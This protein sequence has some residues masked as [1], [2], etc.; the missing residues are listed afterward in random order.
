MGLL[1]KSK[2]VPVP[3][4][5]VKKPRWDPTWDEA[6]AEAAYQESLRVQ[7][8]QS[9]W[10]DSID[11]K[12][13]GIFGVASV[14]V[15]IS[16][17]LGILEGGAIALW[18]WKAA[19]V[20]WLLASVC[21]YLAFRPRALEIGPDP[22][23]LLHRRWMQLTAHEFRLFRMSEMGDSYAFNRDTLDGKATW[24]ARATYLTFAEVFA[25]LLAF[26]CGKA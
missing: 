13:A 24:L 18:L 22:G 17:A 5:E 7:E 1:R 15:T 25:L 19:A 20:C 11:T 14:I 21:C 2:Q 16:P 3:P 12:V 23:G 8:I 6:T 9:Q 26:F 10:S 4:Q